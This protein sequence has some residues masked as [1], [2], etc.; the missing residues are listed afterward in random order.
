MIGIFRDHVAPL[1]FA[2]NTDMA[3]DFVY[4]TGLNFFSHF[5]CKKSVLLTDFNGIQVQLANHKKESG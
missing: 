2:K 1:D 3:Q 5:L 4:K